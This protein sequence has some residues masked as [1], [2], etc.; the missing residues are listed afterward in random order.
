MKLTNLDITCIML[1]SSF[2]Y[3]IHKHTT[4]TSK[5]TCNELLLILHS[6][7]VIIILSK[8]QLFL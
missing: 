5:S 4:L 3:S 1:T 7:L 6:Y 2:I 8:Y